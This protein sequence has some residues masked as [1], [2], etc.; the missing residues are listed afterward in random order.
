MIRNNGDNNGSHLIAFE[1]IA[2]SKR[3]QLVNEKIL[4][5]ETKGNRVKA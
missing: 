3:R 2:K 4:K 1:K 5:R